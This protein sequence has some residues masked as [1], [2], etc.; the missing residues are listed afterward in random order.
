MSIVYINEQGAY[1]R[2]RDNCFVVT[3]KD[4]TL[5]SVPATTVDEIV[6]LGN[7]QLS[8]QAISEL[9]SSG[10]EVVFLSRGGKFKGILEPGY[11]KNV[12]VRMQQYQCSLIDEFAI[13]IAKNIISSK[14]EYQIKTL[15]KWE[16]NRW[17]EYDCELPSLAGCLDQVQFQNSVQSIMGIEGIA[18]KTYFSVFPDV[19]PVPFNWNGRNRQPPQDPVNALLSLTYMMTLG[20]IVSR[21]YAHALDPFIGFVHQLDYSRPSFALDILELCRSLYCDHFVISLLQR[22]VFYP[23]NFTYSKEHGCRMKD[24]A[25]KIY[26]QKFDALKTEKGKNAMSLESYISTVLKNIILEFKQYI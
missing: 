9:L 11:P 25:I 6:L 20:E 23:D 5:F 2:K 7:I 12:F 19:V 1:L 10:I 18:S 8:T 24:D 16:R 26:F 14:I 3:K 17:F 15:K 21:C 4:E 13:A 22:E